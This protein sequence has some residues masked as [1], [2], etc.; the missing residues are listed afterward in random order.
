MRTSLSARHVSV[1]GGATNRA[2][3]IWASGILLFCWRFVA[4]FLTGFCES[5]GE[6]F[7]DVCLEGF[8]VCSCAVRFYV[9]GEG[10]IIII[11]L[12]LSLF[13]F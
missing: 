5:S 13:R 10:I 3:N 6:S 8:K 2:A 1:L 4:V 12:S 7:K 11:I 9:K